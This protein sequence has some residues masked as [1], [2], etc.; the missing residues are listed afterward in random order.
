ME[1]EFVKVASYT[2]VTNPLALN[3]VSFSL[4]SIGIL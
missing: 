3:E 2:A 1:E 4:T